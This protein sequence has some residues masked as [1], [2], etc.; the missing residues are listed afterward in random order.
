MKKKIKQPTK[1][2]MSE[3]F[4]NSNMKIVERG[5]IDIAYLI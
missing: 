1:T 5:K 3:K 2:T 4:P